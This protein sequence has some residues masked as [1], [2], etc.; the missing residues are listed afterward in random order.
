MLRR[1]FSDGNKNSV[2]FA[3]LSLNYIKTNRY[4][5]TQTFCL[6]IKTNPFKSKTSE[7]IF[8]ANLYFRAEKNYFRWMS[9]QPAEP[10]F[11]TKT[12]PLHVSYIMSGKYLQLLLYCEGAT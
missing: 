5:P 9:H 4:Q 2:F 11:Q 3:S 10:P 1:G 8:T 12:T 6:G 7:S